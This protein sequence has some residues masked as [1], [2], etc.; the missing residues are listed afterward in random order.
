MLKTATEAH[1]SMPATALPILAACQPNGIMRGELADLHPSCWP[2][3]HARPCSTSAWLC[4]NGQAAALQDQ[5]LAAQPV[6]VCAA[7]TWPA[8]LPPVGPELAPVL[9]PGSRCSP[10]AC[11][12]GVSAPLLRQATPRSTRARPSELDAELLLQHEGSEAC[13]RSAVVLR[14]QEWEDALLLLQHLDGEDCTAGPAALQDRAAGLLL[15]R[16]DWAR[17]ASIPLQPQD[18]GLCRRPSAC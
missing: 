4:C 17:G 7:G 2:A 18:R 10:T 5:M 13:S 3:A 8:D 9:R 11:C 1:T 12:A 15:G 14:G 6:P 16:A